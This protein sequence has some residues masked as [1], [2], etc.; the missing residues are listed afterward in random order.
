M[1]T[2]I[3][4]FMVVFLL[5]GCEVTYN[6]TPQ[7]E[8]LYINGEYGWV[9]HDQNVA[10]T[11]EHYQ[12]DVLYFETPYLQYGSKVYVD[13]YNDYDYAYIDV[14]DWSMYLVDQWFDGAYEAHYVFE[15]DESGY[16]YF[17]ITDLH[18]DAI[19]H[20]YYE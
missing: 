6:V 4:S 1:K 2:V 11:Y 17:Q 5:A 8:T 13:V 16:Q 12:S 18:P 14:F 10:Y 9:V 15:V 20:V 7:E 19:V 3:F